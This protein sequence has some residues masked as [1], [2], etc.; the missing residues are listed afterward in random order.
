MAVSNK[1][2]LYLCGA[3]EWELVRDCIAGERAIKAKGETYLPKLSGQT[4]TEYTRYKSKVHFF[5]ATGRAAEGLHG[6]IWQKAPTQVGYIPEIFEELL[7]DVDLLGTSLDQF[8]AN[9]SWDTMQTNWG[10]V[11]VDYAA[12]AEDV[13]RLEA[14][15][16]GYK[17]YLSFYPAEYVINWDYI[18][19]NGKIFLSFVGIWEPYSRPTEDEYTFE[20]VDKYRVLCFDEAGNYIQKI[21]DDGAPGGIQNIPTSIVENIRMNGAPLTELPFFPVPGKAPEKSMLVDL[22]Y[23]NIGHYQQCADYENGKH[24]TAVPTPVAIGVQQPVDE[25]TGLPKTL[26]IGGDRFLFFAGLDGVTPDVK[27][28]EFAGNGIEAM[29][30]GITATEERM[31]VL[32]AHIITGEKKGVETAAAARIHRA[33]ENG[34]LAAFA[35]NLSEVITQAVRLMGKWNGVDESVMDVWSYNLNTDYVVDKEL[36]QMLSVILAGRQSGEI[37]K[38]SLFRILKQLDY[39]PEEWDMDMFLEQTE[40]DKGNSDILQNGGMQGILD[41]LLGQTNEPERQEEEEEEEEEEDPEAM[42]K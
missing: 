31:A 40:Q 16:R 20:T 24:Y 38:I 34:V 13:S 10:G 9:V 22:A 11:L 2:S 32:G 14:E 28:L 25:E 19:R 39:I 8:A 1:N 35:R 21:Y 36:S 15:K 7:S 42:E 33:G 17:A 26:Q 3:P 27:Y 29:Y 37:P 12:G 4:P 18:N 41:R 6:S 5:G 23:E 30:K